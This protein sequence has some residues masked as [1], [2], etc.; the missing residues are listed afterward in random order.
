MSQC[1]NHDNYY[2]TIIDKKPF[3]GTK[4]IIIYP[5]IVE[6][7]GT[8]IFFSISGPTITEQLAR[9]S[10]VE[11]CQMQTQIVGPRRLAIT[12]HNI[13]PV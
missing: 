4:N 10:A 5:K 6:N 7:D 12:I 11:L 2:N 9:A 1:Y 13:K 8:N 3:P